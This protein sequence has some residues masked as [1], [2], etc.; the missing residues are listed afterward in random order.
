MYKMYAVYSTLNR[1]IYIAVKFFAQYI[2]RI[3]KETNGMVVKLNVYKITCIRWQLTF[4]RVFVQNATH[5]PLQIKS[6]S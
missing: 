3:K 1:A 5:P 2:R 6:V 4:K